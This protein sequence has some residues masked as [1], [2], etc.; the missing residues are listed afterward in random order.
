MVLGGGDAADRIK[1]LGDS[2]V[3]AFADMFDLVGKV[4]LVL[5]VAFQ[6]GNA[7]L[8]IIDLRPAMSPCDGSI[9]DGGVG[10]V[11]I[12]RARNFNHFFKSVEFNGAAPI[13]KTGRIAFQS[14]G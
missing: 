11:P 10:G 14:H 9:G 12:S 4:V 13:A 6:T 5:C 3:F 1:N 2:I 7:A 8:K